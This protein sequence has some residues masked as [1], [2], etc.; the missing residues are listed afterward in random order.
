M[1]SMQERVE[2]AR[3]AQAHTQKD[4]VRIKQELLAQAQEVLQ[5]DPRYQE[6]V[7]F[8]QCPELQ[9]IVDYLAEN[10]WY[11]SEMRIFHGTSNAD[12]LKSGYYRAPKSL[13]GNKTIPYRYEKQVPPAKVVQLPNIDISQIKQTTDID[14]N[15]LVETALVRGG[16]SSF[17]SGKQ[18][19][20]NFYIMMFED[21]MDKDYFILAEGIGI[22]KVKKMNLNFRVTLSPNSV[23][24]LLYRAGSVDRGFTATNPESF[25]EGIANQIAKGSD[26]LEYT[27]V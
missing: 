14:P 21:P 17:Y 1:P 12:Y 25:L 6:M 9:E 16:V 20:P 24:S 18:V 7:A 26:L 15:F 5:Q 8:L 3:A 23:N 11:K 10:V 19:T 22:G 13:V 27:K 2:A 4:E